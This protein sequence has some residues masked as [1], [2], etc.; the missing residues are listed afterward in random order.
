MCRINN[1]KA[2]PRGGVRWDSIHVK[3]RDRLERPVPRTAGEWSARRAEPSE[4]RTRLFLSL[5]VVPVGKLTEL[6]A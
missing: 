6:C 1:S 3:F 5:G 4:G 2:R